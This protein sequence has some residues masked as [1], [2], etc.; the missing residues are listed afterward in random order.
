MKR[1][2]ISAQKPNFIGCWDLENKTFCD[3]IIAFFENNKNLSKEGVT[4]HGKNTE[5]KKTTDI[6]I[7]PKDLEKPKFEI[8]KKYFKE[9]HKCYMDYQE[10]WPF[11]K[12]IFKNVD[13]GVFNVQKYNSGDH[14]AHLHC[15]RTSLNSL[16]RLF[17]DMTYIEK[18]DLN[19]IDNN[20][21]NFQ[22]NSFENF[23]INGTCN[24]SNR[25]LNGLYFLLHH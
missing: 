7:A 1:I 18:L 23:K 24:Q 8:F 25:P 3:E 21:N 20:K 13:I 14:F 6:T 19:N 2:D 12:N 5:A 22:V 17:K 16:H 10:Q 4:T 15:E 11:V 9:L